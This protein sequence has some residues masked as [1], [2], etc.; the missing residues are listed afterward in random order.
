MYRLYLIKVWLMDMVSIPDPRIKF[1]WG[2]EKKVR[3]IKVPRVVQLRTMAKD[4]VMTL[5]FG[6][7]GGGCDF[8][9]AAA[10]HNGG[11]DHLRRRARAGARRPINGRFVG[12]TVDDDWL[13]GCWPAQRSTRRGAT[14]ET[15]R[16][17]RERGNVEEQRVRLVSSRPVKPSKNSINSSG[18]VGGHEPDRG[19]GQLSVV[20]IDRRLAFVVVDDDW[21]CCEDAMAHEKAQPKKMRKRKEN[22]RKKKEEEGE[23][24]ENKKN[25]TIMA[26]INH[27]EIVVEESTGHGLWR[28]GGSDRVIDGRRP[29]AK[30][31]DL[32]AALLSPATPA[33]VRPSFVRTAIET[34][35]TTVYCIDSASHWSSHRF[36]QV[37]SGRLAYQ[38]FIGYIHATLKGR[39]VIFS[40]ARSQ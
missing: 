17:I 20:L 38:I 30:D 10:L 34:E 27:G 13:H 33:K 25:D 5:R 15:K 18:A 19:D 31:S 8:S 2:K 24:E 37:G 4:G 6:G 9:I 29:A 23:E 28:A 22:E 21:V 39:R 3:Q 26:F 12:P 14:K 35:P 36:S 16:I 32:G 40:Y 11:R 1:W 7:G